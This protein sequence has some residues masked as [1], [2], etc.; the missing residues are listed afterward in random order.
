MCI[1]VLILVGDTHFD[2]ETK[3]C[4]KSSYLVMG[5]EFRSKVFTN[6]LGNRLDLI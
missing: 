5:G 6:P 1:Q 3:N 4:N 2:F